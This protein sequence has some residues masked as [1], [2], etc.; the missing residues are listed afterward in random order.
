METIVVGVDGSDSGRAALEFATA[1]AA[2]HGATLR[3]V[4]AWQVPR[5]HMPPGSLQV[6][7]RL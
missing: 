1:E 7:M 4:C 3:I 6:W 5:L 2:A